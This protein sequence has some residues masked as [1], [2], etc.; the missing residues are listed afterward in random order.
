MIF[1]TVGTQG[2]FNRLVQAVDQ[3]A[4]SRDVADV[5]AQTSTSDYRPQYIQHKPFLHPT[6]FRRFVESARLV[7]AHAGMGS[8]I[9]ALELGKPILVM[10]RR[11]DLGEHRNDHQVATAKRFGEQGRITVAFDKQTLFEKL[12]RVEDL[13]QTDRLSAQASPELIASIRA[14]VRHA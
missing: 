12:D 6:E 4:G 13:R 14:F 8:I 9:T 3:W 2:H 5:F 10:P 11:G 1:L 7:I